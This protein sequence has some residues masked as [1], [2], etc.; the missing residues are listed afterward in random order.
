MRLWSL[1]PKY[2]DAKGLVA[3]WR[4]GLLARKVLNCQTRGYRN[5]PQLDRFRA[6]PSP[7]PAIDAYL[8]VVLE[9][10]ERR[11][12]KFDKSKIQK[13]PVNFQIDVAQG[14]IMYE[15]MHLRSKLRKRDQVIY[16]DLQAVDVPTTH[17]L[18]RIVKGPVEDW[19]RPRYYH[20][21]VGPTA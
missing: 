4:E 16:H 21:Q 8:C 1:H 10:A 3:L 2:L 14:Q 20:Y 5:H 13:R 9:E 6:A 19:E 12:Y 7:I 18:F 11:G 17:P 15:L